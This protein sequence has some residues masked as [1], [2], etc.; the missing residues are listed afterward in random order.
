MLLCRDS[1]IDTLAWSYS[2]SAAWFQTMIGRWYECD[3]IL[4]KKVNNTKL[5][6]IIVMQFVIFVLKMTPTTNRIIITLE[7][8]S[9][10]TIT[11]LCHHLSTCTVVSWFYLI[12]GFTLFKIKH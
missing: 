2:F 8:N 4:A 5:L 3:M 12:L 11:F 7:K 10:D 1:D 6:A 9:F